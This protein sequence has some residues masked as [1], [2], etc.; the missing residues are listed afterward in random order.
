MF[1]WPFQPQRKT[2]NPV[3]KKFTLFNGPEQKIPCSSLPKKSNTILSSDVWTCL[4]L[5]DKEPNPKDWQH[6]GTQLFADSTPTSSNYNATNN[7]WHQSWAASYPPLPPAPYTFEIVTLKTI[8]WH[9]YCTSDTSAQS[10][11]HSYITP[12][13]CSAHVHTS[14]TTHEHTHM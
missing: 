8:P 4:P 3:T 14:I 12:S 6:T 1:P 13:A 7:V 5:Q 9:P 11:T 10:A 2:F